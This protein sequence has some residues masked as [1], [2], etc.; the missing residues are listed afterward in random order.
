MGDDRDIIQLDVEGNERRKSDGRRRI[1][2]T[3]RERE[4]LK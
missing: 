1:R 4:E 2:L 3:A